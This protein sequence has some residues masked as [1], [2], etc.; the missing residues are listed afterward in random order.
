MMDLILD[1]IHQMVNGKKSL[2]LVQIV[3]IL[4]ILQKQHVITLIYYI[5]NA[6]MRKKL[7][8]KK[9]NANYMIQRQ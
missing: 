1:M 6:A 4:L 7:I 8:H 9:D 5:L 2:H 3:K